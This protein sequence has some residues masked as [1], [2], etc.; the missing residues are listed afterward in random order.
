M[1]TVEIIIDTDMLTVLAARADISEATI[2]TLCGS[3]YSIT[4]LKDYEVDEIVDSLAS[5]KENSNAVVDLLY[6]FQ[7]L[8]YSCVNDFTS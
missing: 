5:N 8:D 4:E 3:V 2:E 7:Q 6:M 1:Q